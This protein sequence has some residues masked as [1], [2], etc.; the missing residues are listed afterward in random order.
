MRKLSTPNT[1][2]HVHAI[3]V[4][5]R[6]QMMST[7]CISKIKQDV[8]NHKTVKLQYDTNVEITKT[9][10]DKER[11]CGPKKR[12]QARLLF[13]IVVSTDNNLQ[14]NANNIHAVLF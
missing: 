12:L 5:I 14:I 9:M 11:P 13:A 2:I 6:K 10:Q 3:R 7:A 4:L 1:M 8:K